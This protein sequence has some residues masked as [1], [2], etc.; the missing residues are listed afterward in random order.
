MIDLDILKKQPEF[1]ELSRDLRAVTAIENGLGQHD[2]PASSLQKLR[3]IKEDALQN[4]SI[5]I[6]NLQSCLS[7]NGVL[8]I[9]ADWVL[10]SILYEANKGHSFLNPGYECKRL[11]IVTGPGDVEK[12][13]FFK[14]DFSD[15]EDLLPLVSPTLISRRLFD[16]RTD[17]STSS[18]YK[19]KEP[20]LDDLPSTKEQAL[21]IA[22]ERSEDYVNDGYGFI[23][24]D[25][26][27]SS[28]CMSLAKHAS[29]K[30]YDI[31]VIYIGNCDAL[32]FA[33]EEERYNFYKYADISSRCLIFDRSSDGEFLPVADLLPGNAIVIRNQKLF[34]QIY[35]G[36][37]INEE[38]KELYC[39][40][41]LLLNV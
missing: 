7:H 22:K 23:I 40:D 24:E 15:P 5:N 32:M 29:S 3:L 1:R 41:A 12:T 8:G 37:V 13:S 10:H 28:Y 2:F 33:P 30:G 4:I 20:R 18:E 36:L 16:P 34:H 19:L 14:S 6:E 9:E 31:C 17:I 39:P 27:S 21:K 25:T 38:S 26:F 35:R 11:W